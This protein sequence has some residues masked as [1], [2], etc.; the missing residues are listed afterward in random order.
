MKK[1]FL[2]AIL[3]LALASCSSE[4]NGSFSAQNIDWALIGKGLHSGNAIQ[5]NS[6]ITNPDDW[7]QLL[8]LLTES[9]Y[10]E[11]T[12]TE[13]DFDNYQLIVSIDQ[14]RPHSGYSQSI[15]NI[16]EKEDAIEVSVLSEESDS[17]YAVIVQPHHIVK[18]PKSDKPVVFE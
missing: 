18:I 6:V 16:I 12:E 13:I 17:G 3:T 14:T 7:N 2:I 10:V 9:V 8:I 15:T 11:F 1:I 5:Q 4:D